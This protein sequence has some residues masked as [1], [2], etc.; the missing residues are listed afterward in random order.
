MNCSKR[1][2]SKFDAMLAL[3][4]SDMKQKLYDTHTK[5]QECRMYWC[6]KC[7]GYHLTSKPKY[8]WWYMTRT[9]KQEGEL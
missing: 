4:Q 9:I 7:N 3:A 1:K 5:R 6:G 2:Y 8:A